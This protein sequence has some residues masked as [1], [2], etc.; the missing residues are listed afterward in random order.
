MYIPK[1]L[2]EVWQD[3]LITE[4]AKPYFQR[5]ERFLIER[6]AAQATIFPPSHEWFN[7]LRYTPFAEVK[8]VIL[9][10]DPYHGSGQANGLS[11]SVAKGVPLPPS[12]RNIYRELVDD[13][14]VAWPAEGD[15]TPWAKQGVLLLNA[16]LT[17][18]EKQAGS[19]G[20]QGW[21][22]FTDEIIRLLNEQR[23]Q[24]V[25]VLWGAYAQRKAAMVDTHKHLVLAAP[26]PSPLS[27]YRGFFGSKPFSQANAY[28]RSQQIAP[29]D[30]ALPAGAQGNLF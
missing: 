12:L 5:L 11:F 8:V 13:L 24:L 22:I 6:E 1:E 17:V 18:E 16:V 2:D 10:Q 7:A 27:S 4:A 30:W 25:F 14:G 23:E 9:G 28:L 19:H 29:I 26:H 20:Q 15:L 3:L 21:E